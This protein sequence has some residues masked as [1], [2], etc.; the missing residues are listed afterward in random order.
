[1]PTL[2]TLRASVLSGTPTGRLARRCTR[3]NAY[4]LARASS[5]MIRSARAS[6]SAA[7][8]SANVASLA[9]ASSSSALF[10]DGTA[11]CS[12]S[13]SCCLAKNE[14]AVP[15]VPVDLG[16]LDGDVAADHA[17]RPLP[18]SAP[19][20][21]PA[22]S[23]TSATPS[24]A[25]CFGLSTFWVSGFC[26]M[27]W[28]AP[29]DADQVGQQLA[30]APAGD[31]ADRDLGQAERRRAAG[32]RAVVAVQRDLEAAAERRAV[33]ER[34]RRDRRCSCSRAKTRWPELARARRA[35]SRVGDQRHAGD[36]G[37]D[38]EDVRLAGH[39]DERRVRRGGRR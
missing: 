4:R 3:S 10:A 23:S 30:A 32:D 35:C 36:V 24:S 26:R 20:S 21:R 22:R 8:P 6:V 18:A 34:E 17:G 19:G 29:G 14:H 1:M 11:P 28:A 25:A 9:S 27:T 16:P 7:V 39:R 5:P 2:V 33:D 37:A 13:S 12:R 38:A 15:H 31:Q